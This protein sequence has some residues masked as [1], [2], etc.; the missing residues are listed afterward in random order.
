MHTAALPVVSVGYSV[1]A[2]SS[3]KP[4]QPSR[5]SSMSNPDNTTQSSAQHSTSEDERNAEHTEQPCWF[6]V[7]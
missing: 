5:L 3:H 4:S 2:Q 7:V 1:T 6:K